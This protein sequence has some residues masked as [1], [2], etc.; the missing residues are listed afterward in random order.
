[1]LVE[2]NNFGISIRKMTT[3]RLI[4]YIYRIYSCIGR[5]FDTTKSPPKAISK[6][7]GTLNGLNCADVSLN[8][9]H[10]A[11]KSGCGLYTGQTKREGNIWHNLGG[12]TIILFYN[13][14]NEYMNNK[15]IN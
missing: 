6:R 12:N 7:S 5:T 8:N 3:F 13:I 10:P 14:N 11:A 15:Q 2:N 4:I 1:V 9:I